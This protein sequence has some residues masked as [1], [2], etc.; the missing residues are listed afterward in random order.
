ML[1]LIVF[2]LINLAVDIASLRTLLLISVT[3]VDI[4]VDVV[5]LYTAPFAFPCF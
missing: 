1:Y 5:S 2:A 3:S 4:A